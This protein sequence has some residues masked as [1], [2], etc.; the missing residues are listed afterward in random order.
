MDN[1]L[2]EKEAAIKL[3]V[4]VESKCAINAVAFISDAIVVSSNLNLSIDKKR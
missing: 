1:G 2:K 3:D 4:N